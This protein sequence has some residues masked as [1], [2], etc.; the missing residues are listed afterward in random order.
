MPVVAQAVLSSPLMQWQS[1]IKRTENL[2]EVMEILLYHLIKI[3][4]ALLSVYTL[5]APDSTSSDQFCF[6]LP[7]QSNPIS[8]VPTARALLSSDH[9]LQAINQFNL[10]ELLWLYFS[11]ELCISFPRKPL[12]WQYQEVCVWSQSVPAQPL[13]SPVRAVL[14]LYFLH[15]QLSFKILA[16]FQ[17]EK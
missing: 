15:N 3:C 8:T 5:L 1:F 4:V 13:V 9:L 10:P 7:G 14:C 16:G 17:Q 11:L 6:Q 12:G 2:Q